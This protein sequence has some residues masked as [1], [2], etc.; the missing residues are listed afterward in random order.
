VTYEKFQLYTLGKDYDWTIFID[1]DALVHPD[2]PDWTEAVTKDTV[3]FH[4]LDMSLNR[5][6][7]SDYVRRSHILNGACTWFTC[8][9]DWCRDLWHPMQETTFEACMEAITPVHHEALSGCCTREHLIDDYLVTQNLARYGL[10]TATVIDLCRQFG[11]AANYFFHLYAISAEEKVKA[12]RAKVAEW[13][14]DAAAGDQEPR[15]N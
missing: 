4:G 11:Q 9:S 14:L 2:T 5:F 7:A 13:K 3:I 10:K 6:R 12:M 15:I 1:A 8:F